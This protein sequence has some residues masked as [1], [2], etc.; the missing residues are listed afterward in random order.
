MHLR[1]SDVHV[2]FDNPGGL[3]ESPKEIKQRRRDSRDETNIEQKCISFEGD[4]EIT[5][6]WRSLLACRKGLHATTDA[7]FFALHLSSMLH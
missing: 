5:G 4:A 1:M 3:K 7:D 2:L 6:S